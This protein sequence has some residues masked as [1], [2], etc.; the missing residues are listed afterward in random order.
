MDAFIPET[1]VISLDSLLLVL[2]D[3]DQNHA[4]RYLSGLEKSTGTSPA[5]MQ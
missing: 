3:D 4:W 1:A 2:N 5:S